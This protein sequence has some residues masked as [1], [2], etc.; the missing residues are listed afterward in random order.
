[1]EWK[2]RQG[3]KKECCLLDRENENENERV[4]KVRRESA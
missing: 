1:M 4:G 3:N 2:Q